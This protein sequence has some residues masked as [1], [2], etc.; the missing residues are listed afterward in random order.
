MFGRL[1]EDEEEEDLV[2]RRAQAA[3]RLASCRGRDLARLAIEVCIVVDESGRGLL[4][5]VAR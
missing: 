4:W 5:G 3:Q 2:A 1:E